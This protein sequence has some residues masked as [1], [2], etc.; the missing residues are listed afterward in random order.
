MLSCFSLSFSSCP[1]LVLFSWRF[2][3]CDSKITYERPRHTSYQFN[4]QIV[5][6]FSYR[7]KRK[8]QGE[9]WLVQSG[10]HTH[11]GTSHCGQSLEHSVGSYGRCGVNSIE[12]IQLIALGKEWFSFQR[13]GK[14]ETD[15]GKSTNLHYC[16]LGFT[17]EC[18]W[19]F[20]GA[21]YF[22]GTVTTQ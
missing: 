4:Q 3:L 17:L 20:R 2:S 18:N 12:N 21:Y 1:Y 15:Q 16:Y 10:S 22:K 5:V 19:N 7:F 13:M 14:R 8:F 9:Y 11:F 6:A